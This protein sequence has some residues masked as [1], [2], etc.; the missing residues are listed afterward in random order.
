MKNAGGF[1]AL[2]FLTLGLTG[3]CGL[4]SL[5]ADAG[6]NLPQSDLA[7]GEQIY[8]KACFACHDSGLLGAPKLGSAAEWK[9]KIEKGM[10]ALFHNV[11]NGYQGATGYMPPRGGMDLSDEEVFSALTFMVE[12]SR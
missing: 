6:V 8:K 9:P 7:L 12:K 4:G 2:F 11:I 3:L 10:D 1:L 5:Q